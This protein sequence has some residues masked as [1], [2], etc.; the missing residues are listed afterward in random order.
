MPPADS[1]VSEFEGRCDGN[2]W[3]SGR[4]EK[5]RAL[6]GS[7]R[8]A[9]ITRAVSCRRLAS[10]ADGPSGYPGLVCGGVD[11][12]ARAALCGGYSGGDLDRRGGRTD[13]QAGRGIDPRA[14][15]W[16]CG[17]GSHHARHRYR[18]RSDRGHGGAGDVCGA[19]DQGDYVLDRGRCLRLTRVR[20]R[21]HEHDMLRRAC[22]TSIT[23]VTTPLPPTSLTSPCATP[24]FSPAT[25]S[26]WCAIK[27]QRREGLSRRSWDSPLRWRLS[28]G[29]WSSRITRSMSA[30]SRSSRA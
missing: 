20:S 12:G 5:G 7:P 21:P 11:T 8:G 19:L 3:C 17:R 23:W 10:R 26:R 27:E 13:T 6:D 22:D 4:C 25:P 14:H 18:T 29:T 2:V 24:A 15:R 16:A 30:S 9:E 28:P 1:V